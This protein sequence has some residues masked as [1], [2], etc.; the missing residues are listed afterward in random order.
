VEDFLPDPDATYPTVEDR[1][2]LAGGLARVIVDHGTG[3]PFG[4]AVFDRHTNR[5][6]V[7]GVNLVV[8]TN[9][10]VAQAEMVVI[11]LAQRS[12]GYFD[13]GAKGQPPHEL[14]SS[15]NCAPGVSGPSLGRAFVASFV[16]RTTKTPVPSASTRGR[17]HSTGPRS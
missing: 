7:P 1:M 4:A 5:L 9:C 2:R 16:G 17:Y 6:V 13:L 12:I 3:G 11:M 8:A 10:A 15:A 14:V